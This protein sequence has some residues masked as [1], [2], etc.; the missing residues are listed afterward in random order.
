MFQFFCLVSFVLTKHCL[1]CSY[2]GRNCAKKIRVEIQTDKSRQMKKALCVENQVNTVMWRM[3]LFQVV[4]LFM[5]QFSLFPL[6]CRTLCLSLPTFQVEDFPTSFKILI[7][8]NHFFH[9]GVR[10]HSLIWKN[11]RV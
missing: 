1:T 8:V 3:K 10:L 2:I 4:R 9:Y 7:W 11:S 6:L 5:T